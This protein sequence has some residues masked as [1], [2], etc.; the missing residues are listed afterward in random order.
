MTERQRS[1]LAWL[2]A[3][4]VL[5]TAAWLFADAMSH[6]AY[7]CH[8]FSRWYYPYAQRCRVSTVPPAVLRNDT[9][10]IEITRAPDDIERERAIDALKDKLK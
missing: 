4:A 9:W 2:F 1:T 3:V 5:A 8:R 10:Y 6:S 7:A